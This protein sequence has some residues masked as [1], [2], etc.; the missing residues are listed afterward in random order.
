MC[1]TAAFADGTTLQPGVDD[2]RDAVLAQL[3][4][5]PNARVH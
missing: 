5:L 4:G 3:F 1:T 2:H